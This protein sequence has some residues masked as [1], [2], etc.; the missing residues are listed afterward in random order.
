MAAAMRMFEQHQKTLAGQAELLS[1]VVE[2]THNVAALE[3]SLDSNLATLSASG[4]FE[5]TLATLSAAVQLLAARAQDASVA[6][7]RVE[8]PDVVRYGKVA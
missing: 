4:R 5:E 1:K 8:L 7:R 2:A 6:P 3:R